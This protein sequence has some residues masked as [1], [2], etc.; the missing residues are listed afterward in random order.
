MIITYL[1]RSD[2]HIYHTPF[3][4]RFVV[5]SGRFV[6]QQW[7]CSPNCILKPT[8]SIVSPPLIDSPITNQRSDD[9]KVEPGV[10]TGCGPQTSKACS[11]ALWFKFSCMSPCPVVITACLSFYPIS[12]FFSLRLSPFLHVKLCWE[13]LFCLRTA[14]GYH[15]WSSFQSGFYLIIH[16]GV[17]GLILW[18]ECCLLWLWGRWVTRF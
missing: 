13:F 14:R 6:A 11:S 7:G 4:I 15:S 1:L 3:S 18:I 8:F 5:L 9:R 10:E 16:T 17:T 2:I 12:S